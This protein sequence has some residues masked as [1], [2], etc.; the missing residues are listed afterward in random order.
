MF[1]RAAQQKTGDVT[2]N[3]PEPNLSSESAADVIERLL[4][5]FLYSRGQIEKP[6]D[7][8]RDDT[9]VNTI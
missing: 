6:F 3:L 1:N 7:Q 4:F 5:H 2:V 8:L 9:K